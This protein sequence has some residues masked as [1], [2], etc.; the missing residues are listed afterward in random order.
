MQIS[1]EIRWFWQ[2]RCPS[3]FRERFCTAGVDICSAGGGCKRIDHY[4]RDL[5][6]SELGIKLRGDK[7]GVEVKGLIANLQP[8]SAGPF[9]GEIQLWGKWTS[10]SLQLDPEST[11]KVEKFRWQRKFDTSFPMPKEIALDTDEQPINSERLPTVG[12]NVELTDITVGHHHDDRWWT[13]G[14]ESF[15][16]L[17]TLE[18]SLRSVAEALT[19]RPYSICRDGM[20]SSYPM[21]LLGLKT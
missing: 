21:W 13:F 1:A 3:D 16:P 6:Q 2:G 11:L 19:S 8:L 7:R 4:F 9:G 20:L 14:L 10:L 5:E 18:I 12:C 15:G 17:H